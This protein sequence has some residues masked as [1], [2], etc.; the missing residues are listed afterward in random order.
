MP[1]ALPT[2]AT[3][4]AGA[5]APLRAFRRWQSGQAHARVERWADA[6]QAF[7]QAFATHDDDAYGLHAAHALICA[8]RAD[9]AVSRTRALR[10][11]RPALALAYTLES[12]ALLDRGR[13]DEAI[14]CLTSLPD[15]VP[16]DAEYYIALGVALQ[17]R[18]RLEEAIA[19][20]LQ[21]L[22]GRPAD[23]MTHYRLGMCFKDKGMKVEAAECVRTAL[24][25][26]LSTSQLA[27]HAQLAFLEREACRWPQAED[28]LAALRA[29]VRAA[30]QGQ[31]L[32]T[33]AFVHA[34][35]VDDAIEQ[36]KAAEH[37][38][39]HVATRVRPLPRRLAKPHDGPLRV[40]YLSADFHQHATSQLMVQ[41]LEC[42]DRERFDVTLVSAGPDDGTALRRRIAAACERFEDVRGMSAEAIAQRIRALDIDI[43]V[44]VKGATNG[45]LLPVVAH[46][47]APVQVSWLAFPGTSGAPYV[48]Y[49]IGDPIVTPLAHAAHFSE[50]IAQM[51]HCYQPNDGARVRPVARRA[52]WGLPEDALL[53]CGF[54]QSYKIGPAVFDAWCRLLHALPQARLWLLEWNASVRAAL[55]RAARD[56]GIDAAR[57]LWAPLVPADDHLRRLACA[58]VFLDTWPCNAHTTASE[59]LW[60]GV[61]VVT[62][63]GETFAQRVAASLLQAVGLP[64]TICNDVDAYER[65]VAALARDDGRRAALRAH[66]V[67]RRD[68]SPLYD[69]AGF[70]RD[71]EALLMRMWQRATSGLA[72]DHLPADP[73]SAASPPV[74]QLQ[75]PR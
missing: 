48:D 57:L 2:P 39:L 6:A 40:A 63:Q 62:L 30:P 56:R 33:G 37:Y 36:R 49:L 26:G 47:A 72:P 18:R 75:E 3:P 28:A 60:C 14:A 45:S 4:P 13:D 42:R 9:L 53:L 59:A 54:H 16:R 8:G 10:R 35:L 52:D 32:E 21:A 64:E 43:L 58:D 25:L 20:F 11:R 66:L 5:A 74:G 22:A 31:A 15:D 44:D 27:A 55:E 70:A 1:L 24:L 46:R 41:M 51:P 67:A 61:P 7:E 50:C 38:A 69:A 68:T 29:A 73:S 23:A 12:H 65:R 71:F 19:A 17:R 34:V